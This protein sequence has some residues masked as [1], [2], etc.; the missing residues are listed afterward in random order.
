[1]I[2]HRSTWAPCLA[3]L[4]TA[5]LAPAGEGM[6]VGPALVLIDDVTPGAA[7]DLGK[8]GLRYIAQNQA[9][10]EKILDMEA[11]RPGNY[12]MK[13]YEPGYEPLPD[14]S[15]LKLEYTSLTVPPR[16]ELTSG[17]TIHIPDAPEHW[18]RHY[19]AY[20]ELGEGGKMA[21]GAT[22]RVRARL[23]IE[24][25]VRDQD[26]AGPTSL[27]AVTPGR[28]GLAHGPQGWNGQAKVRN[29]GPPAT[30][31]VLTLADIYPGPGADRHRR[32][33]PGQVSAITDDALVKTDVTEF[34]LA[35]GESR[36]LTVHS[37]LGEMPT[38]KA[39]DAVRFI[40]R[41]ALTDGTDVR[42]AKGRRYDRMELLRL[43]HSPVAK[44][45]TP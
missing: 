5:I 8:K 32:Y 45:P 40:A 33:Y 41:R 14:A 29:Q 6:G 7:I 31:D 10:V 13:E 3:L 15:W 2:N 30:F 19:V 18:N 34:T 25:A 26:T 42:E 22:L 17:L 21:L 27:I 39:I 28:V 4:F 23:L 1:M 16:S 37:A 20:V 12:S 38:D 35:S 44:E 24:T 11:A 43:R 9:G 36:I